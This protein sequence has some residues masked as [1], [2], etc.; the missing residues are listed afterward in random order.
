MADLSRR[1]FLAAAP[2]ALGAGAVAV[3]G[4]SSNMAVAEEVATNTQ[5]RKL[6]IYEY[7]D[8]YNELRAMGFSPMAVKDSKGNILGM[9]MGRGSAPGDETTGWRLCND[10]GACPMEFGEVLIALGQIR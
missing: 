1:S 7:L 10:R 6:P 8:L 9:S 5:K 2:K 4:P 3:V